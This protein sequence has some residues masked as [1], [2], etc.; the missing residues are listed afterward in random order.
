M[1]LYTENILISAIIQVKAYT[2]IF[3]TFWFVIWGLSLYSHIYP[4]KCP[5][6]HWLSHIGLIN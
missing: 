6:K 5:S 1:K 2:N 4:L 3:Y